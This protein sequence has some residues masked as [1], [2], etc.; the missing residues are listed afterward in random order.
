MI[1]SRKAPGQ[2]NW[3]LAAAVA[4]ALIAPLSRGGAAAAPEGPGRYYTVEDIP[5][6]AGVAPACGGLSFLPDGRL[7]AVFDHGEVCIYDPVTR[8]WT[9]FAQGLHTPLGVLAIS[10]REILVCQRPELTRLLDTTGSGV[11]DVYQ[12]VSDQWGLSGNYHEFAYGPVRDA[13]GGLYVALGSGSAGGLPRYEV[14]GRFNP[15]GADFGRRAMY[16]VVPYRGWVVKIG[17]GGDLIPIACGFRQPNGI[18]L[19]PQGRIFVTDNQGDWVGTNKLHYVTAGGFYGHPSGLVWRPDWNGP[20]SV[21]QLDK[22]RREGSILFPYAI[23]SNSPGQP[24]YDLTQ[25]KFGPFAD[26]M[27][28]SE[29]NVPRLLRVM[30]EEVSGEIQGAVAPLYDGAPLHAGNIRLAFAP[31][32]SLWVGQS[33]RRLGW[34]AGHGIQ[35]I[36]WKGE[37]PL[38]VLNVHLTSTGFEFTF[39]KPLERASA[40]RPDS[41]TG[42]RYYYLYQAAYGSPRVDVHDVPASRISLSDDGL[43]VRFDVDGLHAG[44][45]YEFTLNGLRGADGSPVLNPLVAYTANRLPDGSRRPIPWPAPTGQRAGTGEDDLKV[46]LNP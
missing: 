24:V 21:L 42:R 25:G 11:A 36:T 29:F 5:T 15:D 44:Y 13:N 19:D 33:E 10:A 14:R 17:T 1:K 18:V 31:D 34:P 28:V 16:S 3:C 26:Q 2:K 4:A 35:K 45:I 20:P 37:T 22:M 39:T 38:D 7:V 12:C 40:E 32:G 6:P 43:R 46:G 8:R 23:M 9:K 30:L 41:Y 27:I